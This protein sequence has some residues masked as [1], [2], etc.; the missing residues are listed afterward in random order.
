MKIAITGHT[1][2]IGKAIFDA[3]TVSYDVIGLS[4]TNGFDITTDLGRSKI[5]DAAYDCDIFINN[6]F[7]Y[8]NYTDAQFV[9]G[10]K[11]FDA[12]HNE[13]KYIV[14]ISSRVNDFDQIEY[15]NYADVKLQLDEFYN[16][17]VAYARPYIINFRPGAT[18]TRVMRHSTADKM[19]P[20]HV[21]SVVKF[22]IDNL[23]NFKIRN[24]T[25]H[26]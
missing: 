13:E 9:V 26:K 15:Q 17:N 20:E 23:Q 7:D 12:W 3:L 4:R 16:E 1:S 8:V 24:I 2:G 14:N 19:S 6:A 18:D 25:L 11:I 21:A 10:K 5:I 22:V